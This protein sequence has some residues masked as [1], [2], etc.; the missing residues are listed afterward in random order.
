MPTRLKWGLSSCK[1]GSGVGLR[2]CRIAI[3]RGWG[4]CECNFDLN[5]R[6][7][8]ELGKL[9]IHLPYRHLFLKYACL[10]CV[11]EPVA[12]VLSMH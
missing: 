6:S 3:L 11:P 4:V 2:V 9:A 10:Q 1:H 5:P 8:V 12:S 7:L